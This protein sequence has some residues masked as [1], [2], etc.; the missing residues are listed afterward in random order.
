MSRT[1]DGFRAV[2]SRRH[3][4][5]HMRDHKRTT[6]TIKR[7]KAERFDFDRLQASKRAALEDRIRALETEVARL[8]GHH[9]KPETD[10]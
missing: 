3:F 5:E 2:R 7:L 8:S 1:T 9:P 10:R 4:A 6:A